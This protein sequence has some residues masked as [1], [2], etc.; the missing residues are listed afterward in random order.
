MANTITMKTSKKYLSKHKKESMP[1]NLDSRIEALNCK[2]NLQ[3][4]SQWSFLIV[5][6]E[7][8][9]GSVKKTWQSIKSSWPC[10]K[11]NK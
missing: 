4:L 9:K 10:L 6:L 2:R 1:Y 5:S 11:Q 8:R 3:E 7:H